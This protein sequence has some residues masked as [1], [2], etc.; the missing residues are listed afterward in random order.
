MGYFDGKDGDRQKSASRSFAAQR[1]REK[2]R[3]K[4]QRAR[5]TEIFLRQLLR[6]VATSEELSLHPHAEKLLLDAGIIRTPEPARERLVRCP[7]EHDEQRRKS[8]SEHV[9]AAESLDGTMAV[10]GTDGVE[11]ITQQ[12]FDDWDMGL[13]KKTQ[14]VARRGTP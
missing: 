13:P 7:I 5:E 3:R 11:A 2:A 14:K 4:L 8:A 1:A 12:I 10:L 6:D 9:V